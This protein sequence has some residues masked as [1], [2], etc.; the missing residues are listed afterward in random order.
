MNKISNS[1]TTVKFCDA[2]MMVRRVQPNPLIMS[3][4]TKALIQGVL[5][6][7]NI[8]TV[9]LNTFTFS[10]GSKS[11]SIDNAVLG[12]MTKRLLFTMIKIADFSGSVDTNPYKFRYYI[13]EYSLYVNGKRMT[14]EGLALDMDHEKTSFIGYRTLCEGSGIHHSNSGI[15]ITHDVHQ[16]L[17]YATV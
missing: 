12:P 17:F 11:S 14:S 15:R 1:K 7:Y 5:A 10:I 16:C 4:H 9:D 13:N 6:L 3:A 2:Y 8:T